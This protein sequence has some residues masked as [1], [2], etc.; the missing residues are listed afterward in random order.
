MNPKGKCRQVGHSWDLAET[1]GLLRVS[2]SLVGKCH[3]T[4]NIT[5]G[6]EGLCSTLQQHEGTT[7]TL[8]LS[9]TNPGQWFSMKPL[10]EHQLV[11]DPL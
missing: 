11:Y 1:I 7:C 10:A 5:Y 8:A 6:Q 2:S 4:I 3:Q 9:S